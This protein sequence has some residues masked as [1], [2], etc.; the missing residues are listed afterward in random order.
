MHKSAHELRTA[1]ASGRPVLGTMLVDHAS[2]AVISI[3]AES[4]YDFIMLDCEHGNFGP[5]EIES[6]IAA[7]LAENLCVI[8]RPPYEGRELIT[9]ALDAGAGGILV[10]A[11][12]S[13][14]QV[15]SIVRAS[16]Y[17]PVGKRGVHLLRAHNR[18]RAVES[19][20]FLAEANRDLITLVQIEL[21]S[22]LEIADEIAATSGVDGLYVGPADLSTDLGIAGQWNA[23]TVLNAI[24]KVGESCRKHGKIMACHAGQIATM[25]PLRKLGVQ[26]FGYDCELGIFRQQA[27]ALRKEF[28]A[29]FNQ[30]NSK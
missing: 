30:Q 2:A 25:P 16:K 20:Q 14:E 3:L 9:R 24:G 13:M 8:V 17:Y 7:G 11:V 22:A 28:D 6:A 12:G 26:M 5:R 21:K 4:G 19:V 15:H 27:T 29:T 23:P 1:I 18:H 10:P